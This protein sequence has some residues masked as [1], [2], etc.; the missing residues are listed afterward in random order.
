MG[1]AGTGTG[2]LRVTRQKLI[3]IARVRRDKEVFLLLAASKNDCNMTRNIPSCHVVKSAGKSCRIS[4]KYNVIFI[5]E[6]TSFLACSAACTGV[7]YMLAWHT[8]VHAKYC[9]HVAR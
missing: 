9:M 2:L 8:T 3:P 4:G 5:K 6:G 7:Q 1:R